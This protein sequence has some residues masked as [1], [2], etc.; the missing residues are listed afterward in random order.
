M[1]TLDRTLPRPPA[2]LAE[3]KGFLNKFGFPE[4]FAGLPPAPAGPVRGPSSGQTHQAAEHALDSTL[5][6]E[7]QACGE[8]Q[9]GSGFVVADHYILT[10]A[11]VVAGVHGPLQVQQQ[12]REGQHGTVV[13]FDP[14]L[15]VA[16]IR[17]TTTPGPVLKL[18]GKDV[19][20]G[21]K[22]AVVGYPEAGPLTFGPAAVRQDLD[23]VGRDIYGQSTVTRDVYELQTT[24]RPGNSGGQLSAVV[25]SPRLSR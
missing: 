8:I 12:N 7:G 22:G 1:R 16:V 11:H 15:D 5:M 3:V 2:L 14:K 13:L 23:A 9:E 4:V 25:D 24:V 21:A 20:R 6:I 18:D 19:S 17:V 10:N